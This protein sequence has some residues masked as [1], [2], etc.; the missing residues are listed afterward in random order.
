MTYTLADATPR[1]R[2]KAIAGADA[3]S[4]EILSD[5]LARDAACVYMLGKPAKVDAASFKLLSPSYAKDKAGVFHV[6]ESKLKP[7][8]PADAASF[9]PIGEQFGRDATQVF[10]RDKRVKLSKHGDIDRFTAFGHVYA[11]DGAVLFFTT[12]Q[13]KPPAETTI[14]WAR[15]GL[16]WAYEDGHDI[17]LPPLI[18]FDGT[19]VWC[20][21]PYLDR[22]ARLDGAA[23]ESCGPVPSPSKW[24]MPYIRD[25]RHVWFMTGERVEGAHPDQA[26]PFGSVM[27]HQGD[28]LW[29]GARALD[30]RSDQ[31]AWIM[32]FS[33]NHPNY[34]NGDLL[35]LGDRIKLFD[36]EKGA[37]EIATAKPEPR[38]LSQVAAAALA[39][40]FRR[41]FTILENFLPIIDAPGEI[42]R[43]MN[44]DEYQY[45]NDPKIAFVDPPE[46][47]VTVSPDGEVQ[48]RLSCGTVLTQP[49]SCWY[50]LSCHLW[51]HARGLE[52]ELIPFP[53][54]G[55]M[56]PKGTEMQHML[57]REDRI[58]MWH[59]A[60]A[61]YRNGAKTEAR[62]LGHDLF[63]RE[64]RF[65][66]SQKKDTLIGE[67]A[68]L[69]QALI[70][71]FQ[72]DPPHHH[73]TSTTNLAVARLIVEQGWLGADNF[74]DR[75]DV[76]NVLHGVT[77]ETNKTTY[78]LR[79]I[80]PQVMACYDGEA[81]AAVRERM[82]FVL[83]AACIA[84]HVE[85]EA[86]HL[87][88]CETLLEIVEFC[89]SRRIQTRVNLARRA[90]LLWAL[91]RRAEGDAAAGAL[92]ETHSDRTSWPGVYA[93][94]HSYRTTRL[95]LLGAKTRIC[96]RGTG[97]PSKP[98]STAIHKTRLD[99]MRAEMSALLADYGT[100]ATAWDEVKDIT[101]NLD[102]YA[103]AIAES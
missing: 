46:Y 62:I 9:R 37:L 50:T 101:E 24:K 98:D 67:I 35:H 51:C 13:V 80:V 23:F 14:D 30:F 69:P 39:P 42:A 10:F 74:R 102:R 5:R 56:L 73:F 52:P 17:N 8:K 65:N 41:H 90:E 97:M 26:R 43:R 78:F 47:A 11:H 91:D 2:N 70:S 79:E 77:I 21:R 18:F 59:L 71:E 6:M 76:L 54:S 100:D 103:R 61:L 7:V 94:R 33:S 34:F 92:L 3:A 87:T 28:R 83:E 75:L 57:L 31:A 27:L 19:D 89:L 20:F 64:A 25:G 96:W 84:G 58:G 12:K 15:A 93:H 53:S 16:K 85:I 49:A 86:G 66:P 40:I 72:Y 68:N 81:L 60:A 63:F 99:E 44:P 4:F 22:W 32:P 95:W 36:P 29:V 45:R 82:A 1:W 55:T 48:L 88:G 38:T